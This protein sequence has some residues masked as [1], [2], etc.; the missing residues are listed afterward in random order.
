MPL[1]LKFILG[2]VDFLF[3]VVIF[4]GLVLIGNKWGGEE[5]VASVVAESWNEVDGTGLDD[6]DIGNDN[7]V[8]DS[9]WCR[10]P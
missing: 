9:G 6:C 2:C 5:G 10:E 3:G 1:L 8:D 7:D 4:L